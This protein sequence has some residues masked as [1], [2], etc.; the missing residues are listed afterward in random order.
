MTINPESCDNQPRRSCEMALIT[1]Y[2]T[3]DGIIILTIL[4]IIAYLYMTRNFKYWKKRGVLEIP[5]TPFVGNFMEC[6]LLQKAP[7]YFLK[8][9]YERAKDEPYI[10][11]YIFDKPFLLLRDHEL[12][13]HVLIKDFNIFFDRYA[14]GNPNDRIGHATLFFLKNPAWKIIRTKLSSFFTSS[15]LKNMF[16]L[17]LEC[18]KHLDEY[19]DSLKLNGKGQIMDV[20]DVSSKLTM[21]V[22]CNTAFGLDVNTFKDPNTDFRKYGKIMMKNNH[23]RGWEW[24]AMFFLPGI[25]RMANLKLFG[26]E[27][28]VFL[29]KIFSETITRRMESGEKRY[30]LIDILI[31]LKKNNSDEEIEGFKFDGDDLMAQ[32]ASFF[33][34][35][36]DTSAIPIALTLYELALQPEIQSTLRKEILEA[37]NDSDGE[38][39]YDMIRSLSYLDM[40]VSETLRKYPSLGFLNRMAM[41]TYKVPNSNLVLEKGT[42]VYIPMLGLHYDPEYFPEP[43]KFDPERFNEENKRNRPSCVYFP[44]G[45]GPHVCIGNRFGLLV[46][47]LTLI[48]IL[49]K[50]EV[51]PCEKTMIPVIADPAT[52]LTTPLDGVIYL[53]MRKMNTAAN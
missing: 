4:I 16:G 47:K 7:S 18:G 26:E 48:K 35:G 45:E 39:T 36:F 15:K 44:F 19:L 11:F 43:H 50:Y 20:R 32:A 51:T 1:E 22:I 9:L 34:A 49:S 28:T 46:I 38:V 40:V 10:G 31:E 33:A 8:D 13:K 23:V 2:W 3:L 52:S 37:L 6:L 12:I 27:T 30:D 42:P 17:M 25:T 53:N 14:T 24:L 41:Q 5:P 29:R 21:D